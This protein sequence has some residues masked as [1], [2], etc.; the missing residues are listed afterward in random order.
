SLSSAIVGDYYRGVMAICSKTDIEKFANIG[1]NKIMSMYPT[2]LI[3]PT[4][5]PTDEK[6]YILI[7]LDNKLQ[8]TTVINGKTAYTSIYET[9]MK[10]IL[11]K[12]IDILGSYEKAYEACKQFNVF[13]DSEENNNNKVQLEEIVEPALQEVLRDISEDVNRHKDSIAKLYITGSSVLFTN[14]DTLFTEYFGIR[15]EILKPKI[16]SDVNGVRNMAETLEVLNPIVLASEYLTPLTTGLEFIKKSIVKENF[17]KTLFSKKKNNNKNKELK[18]KKLAAKL[19]IVNMPKFSLDKLAEYVMYPLIVF[20]L[21]IISYYTVSN[22]YINQVNK[23]QKEINNKNAKYEE[24]IALANSDKKSVNDATN[25]YK[26]IND[27]VTLIKEQ[28]E[29]NQIGKYSTYNVAAFTQKLIKVIPKNVKLK[30]ISSDDNKKIKIIAEADKYQNI[31]YFIA[32]LRLQPDVLSNVVVNSITNGTIVTVEIG[33]D[34][35]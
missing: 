27:Q 2:E 32:N 6:N 35:P 25:E 7:N 21:T 31:G 17:F 20:S 12:F 24:M 3:L 10:K 8:V 33:G 30:S 22:I 19:N 28:I 29:H 11:D 34:L 14:I 26:S 4:I 13:S 18:E 5:V 16:I 1:E 9:G 23:M 15:C